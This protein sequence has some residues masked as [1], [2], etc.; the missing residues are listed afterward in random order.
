M[1]RETERVQIECWCDDWVTGFL[2]E[3][4]HMEPTTQRSPSYSELNRCNL[5]MAMVGSGTE[6]RSQV[7][8]EHFDRVALILEAGEVGTKVGRRGR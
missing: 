6:G 8:M 2:L 4:N 1:R 3:M 5:G 7:H